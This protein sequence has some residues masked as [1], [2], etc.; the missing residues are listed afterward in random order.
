MDLP[1][2]I[3]DRK[4]DD[5]VKEIKRIYRLQQRRQIRLQKGYEIISELSTLK[6]VYTSDDAEVDKIL[7]DY[8]IVKN[9]AT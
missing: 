4:I 7:Q 9:R 1:D 2:K 5:P 3:N 8:E 6:E